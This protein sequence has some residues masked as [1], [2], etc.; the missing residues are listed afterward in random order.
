[1]KQ[2]LITLLLK[3]IWG[4][5]PKEVKDMIGKIILWLQGKKV[6]LA[7]LAW[8]IQGIIVYLGDNDLQKL[9]KTLIEAWAIAAG[10]A[11]ISKVGS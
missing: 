9:I 6:Y 3:Y 10:R 1:M 7:A 2:W 11:A 4:Y 8:A 5:I